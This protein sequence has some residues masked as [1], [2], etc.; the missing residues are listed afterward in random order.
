MT[1]LSKIK[2]ADGT[3]EL[4][5]YDNQYTLLSYVYPQ[6]KTLVKV[7]FE[8][9]VLNAPKASDEEDFETDNGETITVFATEQHFSEL[10]GDKYQKITEEDIDYLYTT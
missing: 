1:H 10:D 9:F 7:D 4:F 8:F 6:L 3:E 5:A 2:K